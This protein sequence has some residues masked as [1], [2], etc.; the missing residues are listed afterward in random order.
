MPEKK[1]VIVVL[2]LVTGYT[3]EQLEDKKFWTV[4]DEYTQ[5]CAVRQVRA[6][7]QQPPE[8]EA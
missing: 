1:T 4:L 8:A 3:I 6:M 5:P 2:E 7:V